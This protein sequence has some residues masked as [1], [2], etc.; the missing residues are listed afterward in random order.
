MADNS[1]TEQ[2]DQQFISQIDKVLIQQKEAFSMK[3]YPEYATRVDDLKRL[4]Q[5]IIKHKE[6]LVTALMADFGCRAEGDSK[7]GDIMPTL[8]AIDYTI[9]HLKSWLKPSRRHV[10]AMFKPGKAFVMYQPLG[11]IGIITPWNYPVFLSMS[12][13]VT[14]IAAGNRAMIK[15]S[16]FTPHTNDVIEHIISECFSVEQVVIIK[17]GP[18]VASHFSS[19]AFDHLLFTGSTKVG[20]L[21]M[22]SAAK[23]LT[24]VTLELGGKSPTIIDDTLTARD[25]VSRFILGK[26]F[27]AGQTCVAT[28]YILCP[29]DKVAELIKETLHWFNKMYPDVANNND[30]TSIINDAQFQRLNAWLDDAK[31]KGATITPMLKGKS[32]N[33]TQQ[34]LEECAKQRKMPL[35]LVTG[36]SDDMTLMNEEIFGPILPIVTYQTTNEAIDYVKARPRPLALYLIS[37][38]ESLQQ[39]LLRDTHAG[40]VCLNDTTLHVAQDDL[41]FGGI[42]P[43]GMGHYHGKEGFLTFTKAK[44]VYQKG[45]LNMATYAFPPYGKFLHRLIDKCFLS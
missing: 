27:N 5:A 13:L 37:H 29:E 6:A 10:S 17:G 40:G 25:A 22:A 24:P 32:I 7:I 3:P 16:E 31:S 28:D 34:A 36:V 19:Q 41:P 23:N 45:K 30:Y 21:V 1:Y 33:D 43:S 8:G 14:A 11:V 38:D 4:K 2:Q 35:T 9:K 39:R 42:G 12:P 26:A 20:Q 44:G 15:M 18:S